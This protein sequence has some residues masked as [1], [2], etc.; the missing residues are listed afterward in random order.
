M[1]L[2]NTATR[3]YMFNNVILE[4]GKE[5]EIEDKKLAKLLLQQEGVI[6]AINAEE[7][8]ELKDDLELA[9]AKLKATELGIKFQKNIKLKTLLKKIN[10]HQL[11][12]L[13]K[14]GD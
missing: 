6:E 11:S 14:Q 7:V 5:I 2:K 9:N 12:W 8:K 4:A 3:N 10:E 13:H 1:K